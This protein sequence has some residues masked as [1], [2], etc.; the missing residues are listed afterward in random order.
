MYYETHLKESNLSALRFTIPLILWDVRGLGEVMRYLGP[1]IKEVTL[2]N[3]LSTNL[4]KLS[5]TE[6]FSTRRKESN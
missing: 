1:R 6:R 4:S 2:M 3:F 5:G